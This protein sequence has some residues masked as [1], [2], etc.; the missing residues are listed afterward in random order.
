MVRWLKGGGWRETDRGR[1]REELGAR[2]R[3]GRSMGVAVARVT[4]AS[5]FN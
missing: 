5:I 3:G 1:D 4:T 2:E